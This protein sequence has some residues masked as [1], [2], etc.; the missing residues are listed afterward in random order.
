MGDGFAAGK[1]LLF[2]RQSLWVERAG[3]AGWNAG[4]LSPRGDSAGRDG[5]AGEE[6]EEEEAP[7][8]AGVAGDGGC[9]A[10]PLLRFGAR[11][12]YELAGGD[13]FM[14]LEHFIWFL[15]C[16]CSGIISP[17]SSKPLV[18]SVLSEFE[19]YFLVHFVV[20]ILLF[21]WL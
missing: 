10:A 18:M 11:N 17:A 4:S 5:R 6:E 13:I 12:Q 15:K 14:S 16:L 19:G 2:L 21:G 3:G 9:R 8:G 7:R 20:S 1:G